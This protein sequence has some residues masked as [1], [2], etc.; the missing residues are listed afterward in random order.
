MQKDWDSL[1][2]WRKTIKHF[3]LMEFRRNSKVQ[4]R[5][6]IWQKKKITEQYLSREITKTGMC[7]TYCV[8]CVLLITTNDWI[9]ENKWWRIG[10]YL[11]EYD[12]KRFTF[13]SFTSFLLCNQLFL[14]FVWNIC[15]SNSRVTTRVWW[16]PSTKLFPQMPACQLALRIN[17]PPSIDVLFVVVKSEINTELWLIWHIT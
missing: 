4:T 3:M 5:N 17:H 15:L 12:N 2:R 1:S 10:N 13:V 7:C 9:P 8:F 11:P 6:F 14:V 16:C